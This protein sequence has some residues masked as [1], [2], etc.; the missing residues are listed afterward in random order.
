MAQHLIDRERG[1]CGGGRR[2]EDE[3]GDQRKEAAANHGVLSYKTLPPTMVRSIG[4]SLSTSSETV[5]G[6]AEKTMMSARRPG[7]SVPLIDSSR[8]MNAPLRVYMR[9][10][11]SM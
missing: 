1:L 4:R 2:S 7:S 6:F 11:S 9:N 8:V 10:A 3:R 5:R